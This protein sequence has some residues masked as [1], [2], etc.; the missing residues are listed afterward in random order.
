M[1]PTGIVNTEL[2]S[3]NNDDF[4]IEPIELDSYVMNNSGGGVQGRNNPNNILGDEFVGKSG[5]TGEKP[6]YTDVV[7]RLTS[8]PLEVAEKRIV[9]ENKSYDL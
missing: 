6:H 9:M 8:G 4:A 7:R 3:T 2:N 5:K 1:G